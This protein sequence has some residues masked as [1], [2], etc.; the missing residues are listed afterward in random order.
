[1]GGDEGMNCRHAEVAVR[2]S[3]EDGG[4]S[5]VFPDVQA[6]GGRRGREAVNER[7]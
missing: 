6:D 4:S 3:V 2:W 5:P 7:V 1:M